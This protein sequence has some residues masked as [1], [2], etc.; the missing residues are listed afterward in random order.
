MGGQTNFPITSKIK[1][2][3]GPRMYLTFCNRIP[4]QT[5]G[6]RAKNYVAA[7]NYG[8]FNTPVVLYV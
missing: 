3:T 4:A 7:L 5:P 6:K 8:V 1:T 2:R